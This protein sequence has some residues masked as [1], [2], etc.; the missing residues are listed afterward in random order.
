MILKIYIILA[1]WQN[2]DLTLFGAE[3]DDAKKIWISLQK[4]IVLPVT[5]GSLSLS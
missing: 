5:A 1:R 3:T 2:G 4:I